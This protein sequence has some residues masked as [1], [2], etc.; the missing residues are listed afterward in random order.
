MPYTVNR[1]GHVLTVRV[2]EPKFA[3]VS[4]GLAELQ[5]LLDAG[6][7]SE[8]H[9]GFDDAAWQTAWVLG[10]LTS[11][12]TTMAD[13]GIRVQVLGQDRRVSAEEGRELRERPV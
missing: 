9:V 10:A 6:G 1:S 4:E 8:V 11:F 5:K 12:E 3:E 13:F 7:I 2:T